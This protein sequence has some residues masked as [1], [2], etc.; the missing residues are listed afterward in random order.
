MARLFS[1]MLNWEDWPLDQAI[2]DVLT[3]WGDSGLTHID[4]AD[5]DP[6]LTPVLELHGED[7]VARFTRIRDAL[8]RADYRTAIT[9]TIAQNADVMARR[10]GGPWVALTPDD[11]IKVRYRSEP[12]A[13]PNREQLPDLWVHPYFLGALKQVGAEVM[14]LL[15]KDAPTHIED[16]QEEDAA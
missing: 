12:Q 1:A 8:Q 14:N 2:E 5:L 9:E 3:M 15:P 7:G 11:R 16:M 10:R 4:D 13:L 6:I